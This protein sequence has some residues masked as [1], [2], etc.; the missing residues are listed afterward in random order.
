[1]LDNAESGRITQ[2]AS[3]DPSPDPSP[4]CAHD[5]R[6]WHYAMES[7]TPRAYGRCEACERDIIVLLPRRASDWYGAAYEPPAWYTDR[8][9]AADRRVVVDA[10]EAAFKSPRHSGQLTRLF[11]AKPHVLA[12][13]VRS[14]VADR[15]RQIT[16]DALEARAD[17]LA[18]AEDDLARVVM[19]VD[20]AHEELSHVK[21]QIRGQRQALRRIVREQAE[22]QVRLW[23][24]EPLMC[25]G[26]EGVSWVYALV[27]SDAPECHRYIGSTSAPLMRYKAHTGKTAAP[28]VRAWAAECAMRGATVQMVCVW[29]GIGRDAAYQIESRMIGEAKARGMADLNTSTSTQ[30]VA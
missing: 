3:P 8:A 4:E 30:R 21:E 7:V 15:V 13:V 16:A 18:E 17:K 28:N 26:G 25:A 6:G 20:E 2:G 23:D 22:R 29:Q 14:G 9:N 19:L 1:M 27:A 24:A 12:E 11:D 5:V 10:A